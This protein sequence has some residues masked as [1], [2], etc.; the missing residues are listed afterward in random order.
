MT[1]S[2]IEIKITLMIFK[3]LQTGLHLIALDS[4]GAP[5][6]LSSH[7]WMGERISRTWIHD[8]YTY[9]ANCVV[10]LYG[11]LPLYLAL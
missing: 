2:Q 6:K 7:A 8:L 4:L 9:V 1:N 10:L 5:L 3:L 11:Y